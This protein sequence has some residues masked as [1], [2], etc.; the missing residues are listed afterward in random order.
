MKLLLIAAGV[1][2]A[3]SALAQEMVTSPKTPLMSGQEEPLIKEGCEY[4]ETINGIKIWG[5][6]CVSA[7]QSTEVVTPKK[8]A[9]SKKPRKRKTPPLEGG[10]AP[11]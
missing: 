7:S 8:K 9:I 6:D 10:A 11:T 1:I 4:L 3:T 2:V 5:G